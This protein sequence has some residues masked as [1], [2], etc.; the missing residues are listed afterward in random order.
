MEK[1]TLINRLI[2]ELTKDYADLETIKSLIQIIEKNKAIIEVLSNASE[3]N[4]QYLKRAIN[5]IKIYGDTNYIAN[6]L[7]NIHDD[8]VYMFLTS[9]KVIE[10][11]KTDPNYCIDGSQILMQYRNEKE[12]LIQYIHE[13]LIKLL[14]TNLK[15][16]DK[17]FKQFFTFLPN[18]EFNAKIMLEFLNDKNI[19]EADI[20]HIVN[21]L[22]LILKYS[23]DKFEARTILGILHD[24]TIITAGID[25][26]GIVIEKV[27]ATNNDKSYWFENPVFIML[28]NPNVVKA[29]SSY[30]KVISHFYE[31]SLSDCDGNNA[32]PSIYLNPIL[33]SKAI[34]E[35]PIKDAND[36][37]SLVYNFIVNIGLEAHN[38]SL[39]LL[40]AKMKSL[41]AYEDLEVELVD[42]IEKLGYICKF[43]QHKNVVAKNT[44]YIK[45]GISLLL[46][47]RKKFVLKDIYS[48][49]T[50]PLVSDE[51][52]ELVE[53]R[54]LTATTREEAEKIYCN[55]VFKSIEEYLRE[56]NR[57]KAKYPSQQPPT[58]KLTITS[59]N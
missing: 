50:M 56:V 8:N 30:A 25:Y 36:I 53:K 23:T 39:Q 57:L 42:P 49:L 14:E 48:I 34:T 47:T 29:G 21:D 55:I 17:R 5:I 7:I 28:T 9:K 12:F 16:N 27:L 22:R 41:K 3:I 24:K 59:K 58:K 4:E 31:K 2:D 45:K 19:G 13:L 10:R 32:I 18:C 46:E 37:I 54:L 26:A 51:I 1:N 44:E 6:L 40:N 38:Y 11:A 43:L 35:M 15:I 52:L 33:T 20:E